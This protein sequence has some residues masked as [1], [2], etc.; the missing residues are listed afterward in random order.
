MRSVLALPTR[1]G[2]PSPL[3]PR[4]RFDGRADPIAE[5]LSPHAGGTSGPRQHRQQLRHTR[6]PRLVAHSVRPSPARAVPYDPD[7]WLPVPDPAELPS[8]EDL[9]LDT[10]VSP[11]PARAEPHDPAT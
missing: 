11:S 7:S 8:L 9:L 4:Q 1:I 10:L 5:H 6:R 3:S 2:V